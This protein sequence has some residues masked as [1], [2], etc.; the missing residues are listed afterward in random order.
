MD[1]YIKREDAIRAVLDCEGVGASQVRENL[2]AADVVEVIRCGHCKYAD[3]QVVLSAYS[4]IPCYKCGIYKS[5]HPAS[6][7]CY[8]GRRRD[9]GK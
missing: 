5:Y 7:F 2:H 1:E 6:F 8:D 9:D 4:G 3:K